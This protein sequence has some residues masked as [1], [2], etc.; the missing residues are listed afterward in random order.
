MYAE[1]G[2]LPP[3]HPRPE[4]EPLEDL[5]WEH[6]LLEEQKVEEEPDHAIAPNGTRVPI[7]QRKHA[8]NRDALRNKIVNGVEAV[9]F[10]RGSHRRARKIRYDYAHKELR[11]KSEEDGGGLVSIFQSVSESQKGLKLNAILEVRRGVQTEIFAKT[12][13]AQDPSCCVS[14]VTAT[15][16]LDLALASKSA[17]DEFIRAIQIV[18]EENELLEQVKFL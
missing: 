9:K 8:L 2:E 11:W 5:S 6:Y 13:T 4:P 15:R 14:I 1:E 3:P 10:G 17:R 7:I 16:T 12:T 18:L